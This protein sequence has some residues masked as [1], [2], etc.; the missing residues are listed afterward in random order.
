[1]P[2][3]GPG[4]SAILSERR[5]AVP[6]FTVIRLN[7]Q[8]AETLAAL[9]QKSFA[10]SFGM[11][12]GAPNLTIAVGDLVAVTIFE[13]ASGGL[14]SGDPGSLGGSKS[15]TLPPQP[16]T[17]N[18]TLS[19]PY[20]GQVRAAGL[21][22]E[23]VG[24]QIEIQLKDKAIE[25]QVVVT[26]TQSTTHVTVA[27]DVAKPS[28]VPLS[29]RGDRLLDIITTVG[30]PRGR[31]YDTFV[32]LT[33]GRLSRTVNWARVIR[34]PSQNIYVRP[35]DL[36][37]VYTDPQTY[38]VF[39][40]TARNTILPLDTEHVTLVEAVGRAGGLLDV[41][42]DPRG[43]FV[44]RF[45]DPETYQLVR[46]QHPGAR[47]PNPTAAG[48]PVVYLLNMKDPAGYFA[49]QRFLIRND[50]IIYVTN[51]AS[52]DLQK[53]IGIISGSLTGTIGTAATN[54]G[55]AQVLVGAE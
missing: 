27:G 54:Y 41:R 18:G 10:A 40:A 29:L 44:F 38:T 21:T 45:E 7:Q 26:V 16:V 3:S 25:P 1:M 49:A 14:F 50:D 55:S 20:V 17:R 11:G 35:D 52:V 15:V 19:I 4:R 43:V 23:Q 47:P 39:G 42:A 32:R 31:D 28:R 5:N 9:P 2:S 53:A 24:R 8:I 48:I 6:D 33:R 12:D 34:D 22:P 46:P 36:I 13:A 37:Y 51:A 30:G